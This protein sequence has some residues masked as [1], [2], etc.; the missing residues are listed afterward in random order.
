MEPSGRPPRKSHNIGKDEPDCGC[1]FGRKENPERDDFGARGG[2]CL[3]KVNRV[4]VSR[5]Q[6][7]AVDF[8]RVVG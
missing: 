7:P 3:G 1:R 4:H 5:A 6:G 2:E 8:D